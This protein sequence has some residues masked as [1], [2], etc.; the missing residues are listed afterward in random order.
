MAEKLSLEERLA[1]AEQA[2]SIFDSVIFNEAV[3]ELKKQYF[4]EFCKHDST[5][6]DREHLYQGVQVLDSV[7]ANL[8]VVITD[9]TLAR[10]QLEKAK[11]RQV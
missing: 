3:A 9:G 4:A 1:K 2:K 6:S 8:R 5:P 7:I 11:G 10:N